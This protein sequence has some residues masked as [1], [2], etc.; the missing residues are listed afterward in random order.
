MRG[1]CPTLQA[2]VGRSPAGYRWFCIFPPFSFLSFPPVSGQ[3]GCWGSE[4]LG[5]SYGAS[6]GDAGPLP[7]S[8]RRAAPGLRGYKAA[9][10]VRALAAMRV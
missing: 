1:V 9:A 10:T 4:P 3:R 6:V 7:W 5:G 8:L 2:G